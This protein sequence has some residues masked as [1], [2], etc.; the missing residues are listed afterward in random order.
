MAEASETVSFTLEEVTK[1]LIKYHGL[2]EGKWVLAIEFGFGATL[3]GPN[4][5]EMRPSV[6]VA[7]HK[8]QLAR[9]GENAPQ[10]NLLIDAAEVNPAPRK[11]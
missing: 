4:P 8:L 11:D 6:V 2:H 3:A 1:L 10:T 7:V 5:Q 9:Q